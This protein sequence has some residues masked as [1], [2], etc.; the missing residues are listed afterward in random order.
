MSALFY[1]TDRELNLVGQIVLLREREN[2][3][4]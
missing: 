3:D 2:E 1:C 4:S